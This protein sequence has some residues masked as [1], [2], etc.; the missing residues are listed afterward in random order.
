MTALRKIDVPPGPREYK[1]NTKMLKKIRFYKSSRKKFKNVKDAVEKTGLS[2]RSIRRMDRVLDYGSKLTINN[3]IEG[4][5]TLAH[6]DKYI[7]DTLD[8]LEKKNNYNNSNGDKEKLVKDSESG[9][10][11]PEQYI[12]Y[13]DEY[14]NQLRLAKM[15][16]FKRVERETILGHL[17]NMLA[18]IEE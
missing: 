8:Q 7:K 5:V 1:N 9:K 12:K 6:A 4:I 11:L 3:V 18:L 10:E 13:K 15:N 2:D 14:W 16:N 17:N